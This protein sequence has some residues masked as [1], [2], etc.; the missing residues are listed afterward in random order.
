MKLL[1]TFIQRALPLSQVL[2]GSRIGGYI[3]YSYS[4]RSLAYIQLEKYPQAE[5]D[6]TNA[7]HYDATFTKAWLR[8][9]ICRIHG[10]QYKTA[11]TDLLRVLFSRMSL[12]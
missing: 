9:G 2:H 5:I 12:I 7:I 3:K 4:N 10:K 11:Y 8:R 6:A 1:S